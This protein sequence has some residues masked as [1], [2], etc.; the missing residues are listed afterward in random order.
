MQKKK[1]SIS[2]QNII[3]FIFK[4]LV[5]ESRESL[6]SNDRERKS[7]LTP[8][9]TIKMVDFG[10]NRFHFMIEVPFRCFYTFKLPK[11]PN[12]SSGRVLVLS[13]F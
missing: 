8:I 1:K 4:F 5:L 13:W 10:V 3:F 6:D 11:K 12:L 9:L 2:V 7:V